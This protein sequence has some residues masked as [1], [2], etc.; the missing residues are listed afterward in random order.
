MELTV[1]EKVRSELEYVRS[2]AKRAIEAGEEMLGSLTKAQRASRL[3]RRISEQRERLA[4]I[5]QCAT[6][7][8]TAL[9]HS[10]DKG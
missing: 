5:I 8:D 2:I 3:E 10:Q 7:A 6:D 9:S 1:E 4:M